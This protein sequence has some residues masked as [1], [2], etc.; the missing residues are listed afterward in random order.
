MQGEEE[1]NENKLERAVQLISYH[2]EKNYTM[3]FPTN[4]NNRNLPIC[5]WKALINPYT[6]EKP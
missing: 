1:Q 5:I 2:W 6:Y 4:N 3:F